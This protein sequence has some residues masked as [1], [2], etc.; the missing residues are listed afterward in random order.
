MS[1]CCNP[2]A[3][4]TFEFNG[5]AKL[6]MYFFSSD[7]FLYFLLFS[8][9]FTVNNEKRMPPGSRREKRVLNGKIGDEMNT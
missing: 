7:C 9:K 3:C 8:G 2:S 5:Q 1:V 4:K 6:N